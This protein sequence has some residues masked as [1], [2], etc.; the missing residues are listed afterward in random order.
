MMNYIKRTRLA[1]LL[2]VMGSSLYL[3]AQPQKNPGTNICY[4][5]P[6]PGSKNISLKNNIILGTTS[7]IDPAVLEGLS[8][9]I[10]GT[11]SGTVN[12]NWILAGSRDKLIFK[13]D[14]T[15]RTDET[16]TVSLSCQGNQVL[17]LAGEGITFSFATTRLEDKEYKDLCDMVRKRFYFPGTNQEYKRWNDSIVFPTNDSLPDNFHD[18]WISAWDNPS[19][20][21]TFVLPLDFTNLTYYMTI[22][23]NWGTPVF[24]KETKWGGMDFKTHPNHDLLTWWDSDI[25]EFLGMNSRAEVVDTF[26]MGNGYTTDLHELVILDNG[27]YW[28]LA[29]DPQI[30]DMDTVV[31]GGQKGAQ[32]TGLIVQELDSNDNVLFQWR[33]W[34]HYQI[35]DVS[36]WIDL[37]DS[38]IDY[39]HGNSVALDS[40]TSVLISARNMNEITKVDRRTG[41]IIWRWNGDNNQFEWIDDPLKFK[42]QHSIRLME[43]GHF[44]VFDNGG[45]GGFSSAVE[46][47]V[48]EV[49]MTARQ[50]KRIRRVPDAHANFMGNAQRLPNGYTVCGWGDD[51]PGATEFD[52]DG[53][54]V[55]EFSFPYLNYR[56]FK[57]DWQNGLF[58]TDVDT[59]DFGNQES[60]TVL[61]SSFLLTNN[62]EKEIR[63]NRIVKHTLSPFIIDIQAPF[64]LLPYSDTNVTITYETD[65]TGYFIDALTFCSDTDTGLYKQR[66]ATQVIVKGSYNFNYS[67]PEGTGAEVKVYPNPFRDYIRISSDKIIENITFYSL[68]G[69]QVFSVG[70]LQ[71]REIVLLRDELSYIPQGTYIMKV[72]FE[73][74]HYSTAKLIKQ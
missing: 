1:V 41:E 16:I 73:G 59:I 50:V 32:V 14:D 44:S 57:F 69:L 42:V 45:A 67:I 65:S 61:T 64:T 56:S 46:Y 25:R 12:G 28:C 8:W 9:N 7:E 29:F 5:S 27:N 20:G 19:P 15:F 18:I 23:D 60:D 10:H 3:S 49:N 71:L 38:I 6:M 30:V 17:D 63:F 72:F 40:D 31:Q 54:M 26:A 22:L 74:G 55:L 34:D 21:Y 4:I 43:N 39:V 2:F 58:D 70:N 68:D 13:N 35:T 24:F 47:D 51:L 33:S 11:K 36:G 52:P 66:I 37:T 48:D 62:S 53:N